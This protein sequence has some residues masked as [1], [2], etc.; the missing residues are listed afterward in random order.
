MSSTVST[1]LL[2]SLPNPDLVLLS[3]TQQTKKQTLT[4]LNSHLPPDFVLLSLT[5]VLVRSS[6]TPNPDLLTQLLSPSVRLS[7]TVTSLTS[8]HRQRC[9]APSVRLSRTSRPHGHGPHV[10]HKPHKDSTPLRP[11]AR[12]AARSRAGGFASCGS[13]PALLCA[14]APRPTPYGSQTHG[15]T[16]RLCGTAAVRSRH[17]RPHASR[18]S[19]VTTL[20]SHDSD[21]LSSDPLHISFFF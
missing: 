2:I 21:G 3:L 8:L 7:L 13:R 11:L 17:S 5:G 4:S 12:S 20:T 18:P 14:S 15:L 19:R 9:S 10:T 16:H 6:P 1:I